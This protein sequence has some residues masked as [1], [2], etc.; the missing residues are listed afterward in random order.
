MKLFIGLIIGVMLIIIGLTLT[1]SI[2]PYNLLLTA[3]GGFMAGY[4]GTD[5]YYFIKDRL[6]G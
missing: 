1:E 5:I 6:T 2:Y 3:P 4:C